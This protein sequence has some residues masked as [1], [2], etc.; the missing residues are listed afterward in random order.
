MVSPPDRVDLDGDGSA[1]VVWYGV[2]PHLAM[3]FGLVVSLKNG[4]EQVLLHFD[5]WGKAPPGR[6]D[7]APKLEVSQR[8]RPELA[9]ALAS[10]VEREFTADDD[11]SFV[12]G[13]LRAGTYDAFPNPR[14]DYPSLAP[15]HAK[16]LALFRAKKVLEAELTLDQFFSRHDYRGVDPENARPE[17]TAILN[18]Y[19]FFLAEGGS[20]GQALPILA[21]VLERDPNRTV[22]MLN[23]ADALF[24]EA[25]GD[26]HHAAE[27]RALAVEHYRA[28]RD[29]M[30]KAGN[31]K[32]IPKRV[33]ERLGEAR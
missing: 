31:A 29:R 16:A 23:L 7:L 33:L 19:G 8:L 11:T 5:P 17:Y 32:A 1:D 4:A 13:Q 15:L 24:K 12:V 21:Y 20:L 28:Y 30:V 26:E 25:K 9:A 6:T 2:K 14:D 3:V 18:D 27:D 22:A 10:Y